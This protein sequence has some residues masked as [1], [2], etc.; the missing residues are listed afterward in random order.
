M[1][2]VAKIL[3]VFTKEIDEFPHTKINH[4]EMSLGS[5]FSDS[6]SATKEVVDIKFRCPAIEIE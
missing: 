1:S 2:A 4:R 6:D 3:S 5:H